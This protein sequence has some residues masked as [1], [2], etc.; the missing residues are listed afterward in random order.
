MPNLT[1]FGFGGK[2]DGTRTLRDKDTTQ[3]SDNNDRGSVANKLGVER[4]FYA[5]SHARLSGSVANKLGVEQTQA[6]WTTYT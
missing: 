3:M 5:A 4:L 2:Q 1:I 6:N